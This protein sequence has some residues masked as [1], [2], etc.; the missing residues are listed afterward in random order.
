M[1]REKDGYRDNLE[2]LNIRFP[3]HDLLSLD[4]IREVTGWKDV[5]TIKKHLGQHMVGE[6]VSKVFLARLMCG[7]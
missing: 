1:A 7:K 6:R 5:R 2:L 3:A 4:Q